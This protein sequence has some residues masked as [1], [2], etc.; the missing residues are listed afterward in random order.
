MYKTIADLNIRELNKQGVEVRAF[1][2]TEDKRKQRWYATLDSITGT[3]ADAVSTVGAEATVLCVFRSP[4]AN[5][6]DRMMK[7]EDA[8]KEVQEFFCECFLELA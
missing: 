3:G 4:F 7:L 1:T 8:P 6:R 5:R 2:D